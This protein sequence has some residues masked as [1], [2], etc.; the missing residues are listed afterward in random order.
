MHST[1][2]FLL[3]VIERVRAY[4]DEATLDA[5]FTND[6]LTRHVICPEM[7]NVMSRLSNNAD[8]LIRVRHQISLVDGQE[9]YVL[10]PNIGEIY[11]FAITDEEGRI[12]REF[13]PRN[14][15]NPRGPGW[16]IQGNVLSLR[17]FPAENET[18]DIHYI[19]NG[20][21]QPH[22][23]ADGGTFSNSTT[24]VFDASP[25]IGA[26]DNRE[27]AYAGAVLRVWTK[28]SHA[29]LEERIIESY[30]ASTRT[31]TVRRPFTTDVSS[32]H[33]EGGMRY[34]VAPI[35]MNSLI[36]A[37]ACASAMNL[38]TSRNITQKQMQFV[39]LQYKTAMKTIGDNFSFMQARKPKSYE[40]DTVDN[41]TFYL[42]GD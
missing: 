11:R 32:S 5:K 4:L 20:D 23:D 31:A 3:T 35:G 1:G 38:G 25:T 21:F 2:S 8:N 29:V 24:F 7:V 28:T 39:I 18:A 41:R 33:A 17:P 19:P 40:K 6:Y 27:N 10:P 26:I 13:L 22:Y 12:T 16:Q 30:D 34:E 37:I 36:Q 42:F 9:H 14:E 15:F